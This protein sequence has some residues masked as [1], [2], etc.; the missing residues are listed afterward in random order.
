L[1]EP[2]WLAFRENAFEAGFTFGKNAPALHKVVLSY[3]DNLG[4]YIFPPTEVEVWG[5][6]SANDLK[7]ITA[8]KIEQPTEYRS[9][10]MRSL[11]VLF[12]SS[13][14]SYYKIVAKPVNKLPLWHRGKG[15]KGWFFVDEV[16]FY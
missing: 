8:V 13:T 2:S 3:C 1:K 14:Y 5:G 16:F 10:S 9:Q 12:E 11:D 4:G 15:E 6:S 7:R